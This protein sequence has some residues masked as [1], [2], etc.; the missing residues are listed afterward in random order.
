MLDGATTDSS[1]SH[2]TF[3]S[4][5]LQHSSPRPL[6]TPIRPSFHMLVDS[7]I[8]KLSNMLMDWTYSSTQTLCI[9][10]TLVCI[11]QNHSRSDTVSDKHQKFRGGK[12]QKMI[13]RVT[14]SGMVCAHT[15]YLHCWAQSMQTGTFKEA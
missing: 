3:T 4:T 2:I 15:P 13:L 9:G 8:W 14:T 11:L 10:Q 5:G 6:T 7:L 1:K 12:E